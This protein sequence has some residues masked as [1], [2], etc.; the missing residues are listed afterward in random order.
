MKKWLIGVMAVMTAVALAACTPTTEKQN[1]QTTAAAGE[2][3]ESMVP[4]STG[5]VSDKVPDPNIKPVAVVS[6]Y[7]GTVE[8]KKADSASSQGPGAEAQTEEAVG[9][10]DL[11]HAE[12]AYGH[13]D[14]M[15]LTELGNTFTENFGLAK[16]KLK[17]N[18]ANFEGNTIKQ[19]DGD[20]IT[21]NTNYK[22]VK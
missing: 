5:G 4:H 6:I 2:A 19:G 15:F 8:G 16:L 13:S 7:H 10:L 20:F 18:G 3:Q 9:T 12:S 11:N 22:S 14:E 1:K 17:V 21:Y